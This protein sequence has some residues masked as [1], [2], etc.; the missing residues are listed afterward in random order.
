MYSFLHSVWTMMEDLALSA[1]ARPSLR[2]LLYSVMRP[3]AV[4][5]HVGLLL[6]GCPQEGKGAPLR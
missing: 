3:L 2:F 4:S 6:K 5:V 1:T